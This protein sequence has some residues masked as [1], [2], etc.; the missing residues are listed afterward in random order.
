MSSLLTPSSVAGSETTATAIR[1]TLLHVIT[2]PSIYNKLVSEILT[3]VHEQDLPSPVPDSVAKK[4]PYLQAVIKEGLRIWP[5]ITGLMS[6]V[7]PPEGD[8]FRGMELP[9]GTVIGYSAFGL[10]RNK[11]VWGEDANFFRPERWMEGTEEEMKVKEAAVDL[12]FGHGRWLCLGK[13]VAYIE[14]NK[15]IFEVGWPEI[16]G[17]QSEKGVC[18]WREV[19]FFSNEP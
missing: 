6:K 3:A 4:L 19:V 11:E 12:V 18:D 10:S 8:T 14:L 17:A 16:L 9:P 5:P 13:N 7:V 1:V 15:I 2:N